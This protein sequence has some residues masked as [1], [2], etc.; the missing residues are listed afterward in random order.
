MAA[1]L[2][3]SIAP[4]DLSAV[5]AAL[6]ITSAIFVGTSFGGVLAMMLAVLP[7]I[8][9]AGV[10]LNDIGPVLEPL[11]LT[12]VRL[13]PAVTAGQSQGGSCLGTESLRARRI[14]RRAGGSHATGFQP[15]TIRNACWAASFMG[16]IRLYR[17]WAL[18]AGMLRYE[19]STSR[20]HRPLPAH[21]GQHAAFRRT[22]DS[23]NQA[24]WLPH[25]GPQERRAGKALKPPLPPDCRDAG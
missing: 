8:A 16:V 9:V 22:V 6:E 15:R 20:I 21:Q 24:R 2:H 5:L 18:Y 19:Y 10:I 14:H 1:K 23:R 11:G 17:R 12:L 13:L 7:P 25:H 3:D 4:A